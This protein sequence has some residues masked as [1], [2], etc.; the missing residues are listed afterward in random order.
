MSDIRT[1][2]IDIETYSGYDLN[3]CGVYKYVEHPDF[4]I[5]L[6][7]YAVNGGEV[8]VVDLACGEEIPEEVLAALSDESVTKWA[9]NASFERVCLSM[10]LRRNCIDGKSERSAARGIVFPCKH[11]GYHVRS[12]AHP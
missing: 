4:D 5:L 2:S 3:K 7:G 8:Q 11:A 12:Q 10:W 6:F 9:F 1:L